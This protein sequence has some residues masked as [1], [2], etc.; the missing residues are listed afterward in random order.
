MNV[1][2]DNI[3]SDE[4]STASLEMEMLLMLFKNPTECPVRDCASSVTFGG[5][6]FYPWN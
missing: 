1:H 4:Y 3:S 2:N 5:V 6:E